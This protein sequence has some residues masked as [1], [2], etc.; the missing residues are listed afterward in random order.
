MCNEQIPQSF[1]KIGH[2]FVVLAHLKVIE[3]KQNSTCAILFSFNV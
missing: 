3:S 1:I 2:G